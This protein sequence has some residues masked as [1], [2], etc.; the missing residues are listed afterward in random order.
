MIKDTSNTIAAISTPLSSGAISIV[1]L[2]GPS[3]IN[4]ADK[5]FKTKNGKTPSQFDA[6]MMML[7]TFTASDFKE[8]AMCVVFKSPNS[9][10]GEDVVEFQCHGGV[11]I[12]KGILATLIKNGARLA[13]PGE[14]TKQ[15]FINGKMALSDAEG[16]MDM[17]NAQSDA[18]IR[19]GYNLL[20][21]ALSKCAFEAQKELVDILSEL[22]VSF[23]YPEETIEYITKNN[24][25]ERLQNL[26]KK[27][28]EVLKTSSAG[29]MIKNGVNVAIV[30]KPNVGKSSLLN[31]LLG[32]EKAIVTPIAGTTRDI[33]EGSFSI[34][35]LRFNLY[36]TAGIHDTEDKIEKIGVDKAKNIIKSADIILFVKDSE[37]ESEEDK[38]VKNLLKTHKHIKLINKSDKLNNYKNHGDIL[39]VSALTGNGIEDLTKKLY[40]MASEDKQMEGGLTI[41]NQRHI[42][43]LSRAKASI[44]DAITNID[45]FTLDLITIDLNMAYSALGEI[46][47]NTTS[48]E[49]IDA[50]F[51]K[52]CLGK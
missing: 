22:E 10:T 31:R 35:G 39:Y 18:E 23:D 50:I 21:G 51:S 45:S 49:I 43:A 37:E 11:Q 12:T 20:S 29:Q 9:Y 42:D 48:E 52:F 3:A 34:N 1:R 28:Q 5:V 7:G 47:G 40:Q 27:I 19:A 25:K 26:Y 14:F 30:G 41:A 4:I 38:N 6:R 24:A 32:D 44:E 33:I 46:T 17:I 2:S 36:D 13:T 15:A 8:Q 16:M